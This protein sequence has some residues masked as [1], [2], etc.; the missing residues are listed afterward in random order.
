MFQWDRVSQSRLNLN[1][2]E[3]GQYGQHVAG[4]N[5]SAYMSMRDYIN[6]SWQSQQPVER[7]PSEYRSMRDYGNQWM[8]SP[9]GSAYNHSWG[10]HTNSLWE[11]R[12]PQ[13]APPEPLFYASTPQPPQSIPAFEQAILDLTRIVD[14][15]VAENKEINAHSNQRIVTVEDNLNKKIDGLKNDFE[16]KWDNLQDTIENL[17]NKQQCPLEEECQSDTMVEEQCQPQP[18]QALIEDFIE[19]F[20][21][22]YESSDMCA[23]VFPREKKEEILPFITEEGSETK[24]VEE[25]IKNVLQ[26][27]PTELNPTAT[28]QATKC[29]LPLP[30]P[31]NAHC[32]LPPP[33]TKCIFHLHLQHNPLPKHH[34]HK[35]L[36]LHQKQWQLLTSHGTVV[37]SGAGSDLEHP[38]LG[39]SKLSP[40]FV[41]IFLGLFYF[42]VFYFDFVNFSF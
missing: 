42:I 35:L 37:G 3:Q 7:N 16:H 5:P 34:L 9:Y 18:H 39:I 25:P 36:P 4:G 22:L 21:G 41:L 26:P 10:N 30:K 31:P 11:P 38:N 2:M 14:D 29:P 24:A 33:L 13:Y 23:V 19:M 15:F 20:E 17:I 28:A 12:P 27:I 1:P 32:Q 40:L 6:Q 8:S